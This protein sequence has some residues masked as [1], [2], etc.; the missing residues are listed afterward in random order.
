[1]NPNII[2]LNE[3][4]LIGCCCKMNFIENKTAE[5]WRQ[6][7]PRLNE[8]NHKISPNLFSVQLYDADYNFNQ[9][10]PSTKFTKWAAAEVSTFKDVATNMETLI[11]E[12]GLYAV[13]L[14]KGSNTDNSTFEY[15][16]QK[17]LPSST[18]YALD[19]RPHFEVLG[20]KYKNGDPSPEEEIWIPIKIKNVQS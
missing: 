4:K 13:F 10:N 14:H 19:I 5:L 6:F 1:M 17:W 8:I 11:I 2:H 7:M 3:K 18:E 9:F 20:E 12:D 16:F 15:I